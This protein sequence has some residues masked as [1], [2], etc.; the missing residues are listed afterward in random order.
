[1]C[2]ETKKMEDILKEMDQALNRLTKNLHGVLKMM[3]DEIEKKPIDVAIVDSV[4]EYEE[5]IELYKTY[6]G[7]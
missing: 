4:A 6:G 7:D 2:M 1:M 3:D 5:E